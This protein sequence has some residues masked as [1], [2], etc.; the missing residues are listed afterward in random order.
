MNI[1]HLESI[2]NQYGYFMGNRVLVEVARCLQK[3]SKSS[4]II[5]R[6]GADEF[7]IVLPEIDKE[8]LNRV[9]GLLTNEAEKCVVKD[10]EKNM[11]I[12]F[13]VTVGTGSI[14][15]TTKTIT[16]L[17]RQASRALYAAKAAQKQS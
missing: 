8:Y 14:T 3:H 5:S 15:T 6:F 17:I 1:N 2:N 9:S 12:T 10:E 7:L 11:N 4:D 16:E 13:R